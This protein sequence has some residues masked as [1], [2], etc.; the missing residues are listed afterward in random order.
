[1]LSASTAASSLIR[2][3]H[4]IPHARAKFIPIVAGGIE[5]ITASIYRTQSRK[6]GHIQWMKLTAVYENTRTAARC[7]GR[8]AAAESKTRGNDGDGGSAPE[9][10]GPAPVVVPVGAVGQARAIDSLQNFQPSFL[11]GR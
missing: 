10:Q 9:T 4:Q 1:M 5:P 11:L 3:R 7:V 2:G 6:R 8:H